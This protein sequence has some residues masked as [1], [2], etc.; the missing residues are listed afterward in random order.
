MG[1]ETPV[2]VIGLGKI[3][4]A[5]AQALSRAGHRVTVYNRTADRC[6]PVRIAGGLIAETPAQAIA[7]SPVTILSLSDHAV[8]NELVFV[9]P[10]PDLRGR[11]LIQLSS[12]TPREARAWSRR[13]TEAGGESLVGAVLSHPMHIGTQRANIL[14]SGSP[15]AFAQC[16][17][18]L[19]RLGKAIHVSEEPGGASALDCAALT[20]S[21]LNIVGVIQ[22]IELCR[23]EGVDPDKFIALSSAAA[24]GR[25]QL[26]RMLAQNIVTRNYRDPAATLE[27]WGKVARNIASTVEENRMAPFVPH[28]LAELF[29]SAEKAGLC[30]LDIAALSEL[31]RSPEHS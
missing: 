6:E 19:N 10:G 15:D 30:K 14:L 26:N 31:L 17:D 13:C 22:G 3:G 16:R 5:L 7:A 24:E 25:A 29:S 28:M 27:T 20:A 4:S 12:G 18:L 11:T 23:S 8:S 1:M 21:M 9:S 2:S